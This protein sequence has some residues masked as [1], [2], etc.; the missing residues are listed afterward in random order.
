MEKTKSNGKEKGKEEGEKYSHDP[1]RFY[2]E[3]SHNPGLVK[4]LT[5]YD[6]KEK[7]FGCQ[8]KQ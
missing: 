6:I 2:P 4:C 3:A 8:G 5:F 7:R 1:D